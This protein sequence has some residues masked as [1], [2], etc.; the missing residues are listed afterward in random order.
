MSKANGDVLSYGKPRSQ[1]TKDRISNALKHVLL[2]T[3]TINKC[4]TCGKEF[5][6]YPSNAK[7]GNGHFCSKRCTTIA[8][9]L[10]QK[11]SG[12]DIE[13]LL[14]QWL[15]TN[16]YIFQKQKPI[17]A[18]TIPD[19]FVE[20]NICIYADGDYWHSLPKVKKR[21]EWI[22]YQLQKKGYRI[23]RLLGSEIKKGV[24]SL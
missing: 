20:P 13:I 15:K 8:N 16:G 24:I 23:V 9:N 18:I 7:R 19:F 11:D 6:V 10:V 4:L 3:G 21:D 17:E 5:Y 12:T 22:N 1:E 2:K 14:E